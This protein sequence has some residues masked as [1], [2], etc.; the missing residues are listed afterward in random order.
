MLTKSAQH[1]AEGVAKPS[2][3][4]KQLIAGFLPLSAFDMDRLKQERQSR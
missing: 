4:G 3:S 1:G 2:L